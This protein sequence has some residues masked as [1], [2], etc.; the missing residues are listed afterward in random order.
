MKEKIESGIEGIDNKR[1]KNQHQKGSPR[2]F[3][4]RPRRKGFTRKR[5]VHIGIKK[6]K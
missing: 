2:P 5:E 3:L 6:E 4:L 1:K